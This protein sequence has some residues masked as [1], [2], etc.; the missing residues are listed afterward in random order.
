[1][2]RRVAPET[3]RRGYRR[4]QPAQRIGPAGPRRTAAPVPCQTRR[5]RDSTDRCSRLIT[6]ASSPSEVSSR[7][8][9]HSR[10]GPAS[11]NHRS[12]RTTVSR[13]AAVRVSR[14]PAA[15]SHGQRPVVVRSRSS[16]AAV[17][18]D[19]LAVQAKPV[20]PCRAPSQYPSNRPVQPLH[21][22][23]SASH[24]ERDPQVTLNN[25]VEMP[26]LGF[27]VYQI[28]AEQPSRPSPTRSPPATGSST[29]PPP[30]RTRKPSAVPIASS[31]IPR[32]RAVRHH[33][34]LDPALPARTTLRRAFERVAQAA[35]FDY[36]D[37]YLIHQPLGDYYSSWRAMQELN[38]EGLAKAIGVSNFYPDRLVDLI[39]HNESPRRST[40][41]RPIHSSSAPPTRHSCAST[42]SRSSPGARLP[43]PRGLTAGAKGVRVGSKRARHLRKMLTTNSGAALSG[44]LVQC[45]NRMPRRN[46]PKLSVASPLRHRRRMR[47]LPISSARSR[48]AGSGP[49]RRRAARPQRNAP[50]PT[51]EQATLALGTEVS[52]PV[53]CPR[54]RRGAPALKR[55]QIDRVRLL[56]GLAST[57]FQHPGSRNAQPDARERG[58]GAV[59]HVRGKPSGTF[60]AHSD[61]TELRI[62]GWCDEPVPTGGT[63]PWASSRAR[64]LVEA[65]RSAASRR[66]EA[67]YKG[68]DASPR[69]SVCAS[70]AP[71][72]FTAWRR[73]TR[74]RGS[75]GLWRISR[76]SS[77]GP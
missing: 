32:E 35:R 10:T 57:Y 9:H 68:R 26:I 74:A 44:P 53:L 60:V 40:R 71:A 46:A 20:R 27:G 50:T 4:P 54:A 76:R 7:R 13:K 43:K 28:P 21:H 73:K 30:T 47:R 62:A 48:R 77:A 33:Q 42:V 2:Q 37:L 11:R 34:A 65:R 70:H 59:E 56:A 38:R 1:M 72:L 36:V 45:E 8:F 31:G 61:A 64:R 14:R 75:Q 22:R 51:E 63:T 41:S 49:C 66:K 69:R 39:D 6:D 67:S 5:S 24:D 29:P 18:E 25:G 17:L 23:H 55:Q 12:A 58:H 16:V 52:N 15:A 3:H 19:L